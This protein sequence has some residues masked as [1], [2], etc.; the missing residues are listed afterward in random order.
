MCGFAGY[1]LSD[2]VWQNEDYATKDL[3]NISKVIYHRGPDDNGVYA[4][5]EN[6]LGLAFQRLS[7]LDLSEEAMQPM[8]SDCRKWVVVFNRE[9]STC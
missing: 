8:I 7:I 2:K 1:I 4:D 9:I 5:T 3:L 6:R